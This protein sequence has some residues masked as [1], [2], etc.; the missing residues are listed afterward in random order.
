MVNEVVV[1]GGFAAR[2][3]SDEEKLLRCSN[4]FEELM[5]NVSEV[6]E[7][8][9]ILAYMSRLGMWS[10][11]SLVGGD[12]A[13]SVPSFGVKGRGSVEPRHHF[14]FPSPRGHQQTTKFTVSQRLPR[15]D[16]W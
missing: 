7:L 1:V 2:I 8:P 9:R 16:S 10:F 15:H 13:A 5:W 12:A 11:P 4:G 3:S 6:V 14:G